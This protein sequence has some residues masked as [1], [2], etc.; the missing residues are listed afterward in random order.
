MKIRLG[1]PI[2]TKGMRSADR[3]ELTSRLENA[4]RGLLNRPE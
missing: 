1:A 4:V 3:I 2:E